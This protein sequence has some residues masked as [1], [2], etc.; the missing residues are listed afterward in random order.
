M[1]CLILIIGGNTNSNE[2]NGI[3][4]EPDYGLWASRVGLIGFV[5]VAIIIQIVKRNSIHPL[6]INA[7]QVTLAN[8]H[9]NFAAALEIERTLQAEREAVRHDAYVAWQIEKDKAEFAGWGTGHARAIRLQPDA[10]A[11]T[12]GDDEQILLRSGEDELQSNPPK[13]D[14]LRPGPADVTTPT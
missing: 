10:T 13:P 4:G 11:E 14:E 6:E 7:T 8:V 5:V 9:E 2:M 3:R 12:G 1:T